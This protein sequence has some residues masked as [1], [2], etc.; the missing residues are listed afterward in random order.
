[1]LA[2]VHWPKQVTPADPSLR[3]G[4][5]PCGLRSRVG[6]DMVG[7]ESERA[8]SASP[9]RC[10]WHL[11][12]FHLKMSSVLTDLNTQTWLGSVAAASLRGVGPSASCAQLFADV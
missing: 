2:A 4:Q 10:A 3:G 7:G 8:E 11:L 9:A 1:M 6:Q 5:G 12:R